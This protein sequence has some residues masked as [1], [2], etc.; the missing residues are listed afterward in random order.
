MFYNALARKGKLADT[1]EDEIASV[2]AIHN[3][4]NEKTWQKILQWEETTTAAGEQQRLETT[5]TASPK[6]LKFMGRPTDLSP[7]AAFKHYILGH[8]LPFDRHDWTVERADGTLARY[9][10]DYYH[11]EA[12]ADHN[13]TT[14]TT[15]SL[16]V[17]VRPAMDGFMP[18][19]FRMVTMPTAR[20]VTQ[21]ARFEPLP[22]WPTAAM[23]SQVGESVQVWQNIIA[24]ASNPNQRGSTTELLE[25]AAQ[26]LT[27]AFAKT[28]PKCAK[29]RQRLDQCTDDNNDC[30][31]A[32]MDWTI[33]MATI[34]CPLQHAALVKAL[35]ND[36]DKDT[37][38]AALERV[39]D[40]V[41]LQT[42]RHSLAR[43][44]F[45]H[46]FRS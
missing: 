1:D 30:A 37:M 26:E 32:S 22:L 46:L 33:C 2:V 12:R 7:K 34:L 19:W 27:A 35:T 16:L 14:T 31:R 24:A 5:T 23:K 29:A 45:P 28:V 38:V 8:P 44:K 43:N 17:D 36:D 18:L 3:H 39:N 42:M 21:T 13:A 6:L 41:A 20:H 15:N 9:V 11:D 4:M 10:I 40:C 25:P